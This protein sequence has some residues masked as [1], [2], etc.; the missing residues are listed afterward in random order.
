MAKILVVD[1]DKSIVD[2]LQA[3]LTSHGQEVFVAMDGRAGLATA[4]QEKPDLIILDIMMPEMDGFAVSGLLFQDPVMRMIPVLI[5][6]AMARTQNNF[7]L[8]PNIRLYMTKPFDPADLLSK[9]QTLL[10]SQFKAA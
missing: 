2:L 9:V 6:T 3:L 5:L 10:Q 1:D 8:V 7:D 4:K